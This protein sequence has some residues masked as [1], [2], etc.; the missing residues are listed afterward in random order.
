MHTQTDPTKLQPV[1][2]IAQ[3]HITWRKSKVLGLAQNF[4]HHKGNKN[5]RSIYA[6]YRYVIVQSDFRWACQGPDRYIREAF[7]YSS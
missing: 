5:G 7:S 3:V 6:C 2:D 1:R 4:G